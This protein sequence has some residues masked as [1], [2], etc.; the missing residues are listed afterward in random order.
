MTYL[1]DSNILIGYLNGGKQEINFIASAKK[2]RDFLSFSVISKIEILSLS[3]LK[4]ENIRDI[5]NFLNIPHSR[6]T[7]KR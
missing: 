3:G 7:F 5:E 6:I 4:E 1:L 2:D